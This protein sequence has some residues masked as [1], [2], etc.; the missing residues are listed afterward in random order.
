MCANFRV[1]FPMVQP[2][3]L[4]IRH[5]FGEETAIPQKEELDRLYE[6]MLLE[7]LL[8]DFAGLFY[9]LTVLGHKPSD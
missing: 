1:F 8:Q 3:L 7:M 9:L 6:E 5:D 2:F 4:K